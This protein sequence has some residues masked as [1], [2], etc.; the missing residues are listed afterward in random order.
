MNEDK[1]TG[2]ETGRWEREAARLPRDIKPQR[3]LWPDIAARI[4][5]RQPISAGRR[6]RVGGALAAAV[7]LV[8]LSS[9]TTLWMSQRGTEAE[10][11]Q[12][13]P[14][15]DSNRSDIQTADVQAAFGPDHELGPRYRLARNAL[16]TDL[17]ARLQALPPGTRKVVEQNSQQIRGAVTEINQALADDPGNALLQQLLM[18]TYQDELAVLTEMNRIARSLPTRTEI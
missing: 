5:S 14:S 7:A 3:D 10:F 4:D 13:V 16:T 1:T 8:A 9:V 11:S 12:V 6:W 15:P 18:A 2:L 17:D